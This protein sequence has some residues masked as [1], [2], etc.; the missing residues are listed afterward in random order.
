VDQGRGVLQVLE[1]F[2]FPVKLK[3]NEKI[4]LKN[5]LEKPFWVAIKKKKKPPPPQKNQKHRK[6]LKQDKQ[7]KIHNQTY[8]QA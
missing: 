4:I 7:I 6:N 3:K 8:K 2:L 5:Y 1:P